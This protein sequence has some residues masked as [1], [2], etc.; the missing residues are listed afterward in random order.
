VRGVG[1]I[2]Q[3]VNGR[4]K[5]YSN[6]PNTGWLPGAI[7][8]GGAVQIATNF[9]HDEQLRVLTQGLP[10]WPIDER[11]HMREKAG[12]IRKLHNRFRTTAAEARALED[13]YGSP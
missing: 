13:L 10:L 4:V 5:K 3:Q 12:E 6:E 9:V 8:F 7:T 11:R 1:G 2:F